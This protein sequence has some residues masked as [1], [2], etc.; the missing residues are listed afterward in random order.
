M[1]RKMRGKSQEN[2]AEALGLTFQQVQ[3]YERGANRISASKLVQTAKY[4]ECT[5]ASLVGEDEELNNTLTNTLAPILAVN[6]AV[7]M[8][9]AYAAINEPTIRSRLL[10]LTTSLA[11]EDGSHTA[12]GRQRRAV[13]G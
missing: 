9:A 5:V 12:A 6:G 2:L 1:T 4:L 10:A 7:E 13:V 3:K 8:A 11:Y